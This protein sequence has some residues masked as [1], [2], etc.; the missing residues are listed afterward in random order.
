MLLPVL[1]GMSALETD[2]EAHIA[3][4]PS[5]KMQLF[6][7]AIHTCGYLLLTGTIAWIVFSRLG[8]SVLRK[9][10]LNLDLVWAAAL[11]VTSVVTLLV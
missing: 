4:F 1:L 6:A 10:W 7:V 9:A 2:H 8:A 5:V 3:A 11:V